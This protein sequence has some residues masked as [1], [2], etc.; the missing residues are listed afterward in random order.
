MGV[1]EHIVA[2][3]FLVLQAEKQPLFWKTPEAYLKHL[4][5]IQ[6]PATFDHRPSMH[7]DLSHGR[8]TEIDVMNG[9]IAQLGQ[10]HHIPT[11]TN[12]TLIALIRT[13][14]RNSVEKP[15]SRRVD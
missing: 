10:K 12:D 13:L 5:E 3:A 7:A 15:Y 6:I 2:E 11:P 14:Q 8:K 1:K 9:A 4:K